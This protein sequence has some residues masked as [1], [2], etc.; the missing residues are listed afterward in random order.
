MK[1]INGVFVPEIAYG[2][3]KID[4]NIASECVKNAI[5]VGYHHIDCARIYKNEKEVGEGIK[6]SGIAREKLF[7]TS[8]LWND[9]RGYAETIEAFE[10]SLED[11][12]L[13]YLDLYL[14]HWPRP[15]KYKDDYIEKNIET[16]RA[17][18]Y[19]YREGK[20]R[21][22]GVSNFKVHHLEELIN[23]V[24]IVP[25]VNQIEFHPSRLQNDVRE[26]CN[27]NNIAITG[28]SPLANGKVFEN[29]KLKEI[30]NKL[31]VSVA[32]LCIKYAL[33]NKVIPIIK[34]INK[35]R[36]KDNLDLSFDI[37]EIYLNEINEIMDCAVLCED[38]D[39][40]A[41]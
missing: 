27:K 28:Y 40:I 33:I 21:A 26:F 8:K 34:T 6:N 1:L 35:D 4:K 38:S 20:V 15:L 7:I 9:T 10:T 30:A 12:G 23:N 32:R 16:W 24:E 29:E 18:E 11:L 39:N 41:F 19:L 14:I 25:M 13:E 31:E 36:M 22:I 5:E 3:W 37:D 17:F 2:T